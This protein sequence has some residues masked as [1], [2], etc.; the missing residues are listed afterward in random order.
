MPNHQVNGVSLIIIISQSA[1]PWSNS[2]V[3]TSKHAWNLNTMIR[4]PHHHHHCRVGTVFPFLNLVFYQFLWCV[5]FE[6][7][8]FFS[9]VLY[10]RIILFFDWLG[11]VS[12][13]SE[14]EKGQKEKKNEI[15]MALWVIMN[16]RN[17]LRGGVS[18]FIFILLILIKG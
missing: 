14:W 10:W 17:K 1:A 13:K 5:V 9:D 12:C 15:I 2:C 7:S 11:Q 3:Y 6:G 16:L 8:L 4:H 18:L